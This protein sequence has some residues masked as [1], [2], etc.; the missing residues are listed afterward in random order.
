MLKS[1]TYSLVSSFPPNSIKEKRTPGTTRDRLYTLYGAIKCAVFQEG[2]LR[3]M[4]VF[5][6][7][8]HVETPISE[9]FR[10]TK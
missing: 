3:I 7:S 10:Q 6:R 2:K 1:I 5:I 9:A 4:S 8:K